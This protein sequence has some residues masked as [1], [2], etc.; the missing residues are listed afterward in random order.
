MWGSLKRVTL[1]VLRHFSGRALCF[2]ALLWVLGA[3]GPVQ[4]Q[5][6]EGQT[7]LE[8][9]AARAR[10]FRAE[11]LVP[12]LRQ[13]VTA[14]G[15]IGDALREALKNRADVIFNQETALPESVAK[16][17]LVMATLFKSDATRALAVSLIQD[18][19]TRL[20]NE[21]KAEL[22]APKLTRQPL[23]VDEV[24]VGM[25]PQSAAYVQEQTTRNPS[26]RV[27]LVD[28]ALRPGGTF[29]DVGEA[30]FLNSTN[31]KN[32]GSRASPGRGDLNYVHDIVGIPDFKGRRW[33]EAGSIGEVTSVGVYLSQALPL[34][35]TQV[36][37]VERDPRSDGYIV[38]MRDLRSN[39]TFE[40]QTQRVILASGLGERVPFADAEVEELIRRE[41]RSARR[42][43]RAPRL[44]DG[45]EFLNRVGA[46]S[47]NLP[48]RDLVGKEVLV[49]GG[50]DT[51]RVLVEL[52][53][54]LG[55]EGAYG[56]DVAQVGQVKRIFWMVG[57]EGPRECAEYI[58]RTRARYSQIAQAINSGQVVLVPGRLTS[59]AAAEGAAE[60]YEIE[61]TF[62]KENG[63]VVR[64]P[65]N[66]EYL[67]PADPRVGRQAETV[68]EPIQFDKILLSTG[69]KS[70][71]PRVL[72]GLS[73]EPFE[74]VWEPVKAVVEGLG[75]GEVSIAN[76]HKTASGVFLV[77]PANEALGGL[78]SPAEL[79]G[80]SA[81]TVSLYA[82]VV[83]TKALAAQISEAPIVRANDSSFAEFREAVEGQS[84]PG[85]TVDIEASRNAG[86]RSFTVEV[87][88][89]KLES[90]RRVG[91][92]DLALRV[93][94]DRSLRN[95]RLETRLQ[96]VQIE[97]VKGEGLAYRAVIKD[98][99][100]APAALKKIQALFRENTLLS[101]VLVRD[102][103]A[104]GTSV[105]SVLVTLPVT[106]RGR[107]DLARMSVM[108]RKR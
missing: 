66:I 49:V 108:T 107:F 21:I 100:L 54:R 12:L 92:V 51:G 102:L 13:A 67:L 25:G 106:S 52:L 31:R 88:A 23:L 5:A 89:E 10:W 43:G 40:V 45:I 64:K 72:S 70:S 32:D 46:Q 44:E 34:L 85:A 71:I 95:I 22:A 57:L 105:Q 15:E 75:E 6:Q 2:A 35:E 24:V 4:I 82:N 8:T 50:G 28:N 101:S 29:A 93:A 62:K 33:V 99:N 96:E 104:R 90:I 55:P 18:D 36:L 41:E 65:R 17:R 73:S 98:V 9:D 103:F 83:R 68:S 81:N 16:V 80:I 78:P 20:S 60:K 27:L 7:G 58:E 63:S 79:K 19:M 59:I 53:T 11:K 77:G 56:A 91:A 86:E 87:D 42:S 61:H 94:V 26:R 47:S 74:R 84:A 76:R 39:Q 69:L 37:K 38:S 30:F 3:F 14:P 97:F 48:I 1:D